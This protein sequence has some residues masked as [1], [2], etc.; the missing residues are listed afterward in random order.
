MWPLRSLEDGMAMTKRRGSRPLARVAIAGG[1]GLILLSASSLAIADGERG[2][3]RTSSQFDAVTGNSGAS[4]FVPNQRLSDVQRIRPRTQLG[5]SRDQLDRSRNGDLADDTSRDLN[6]DRD[7]RDDYREGLTSSG[8][9]HRGA[10][11][12][13]F[14]P[15][16]PDRID[17]RL[18]R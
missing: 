3:S 17:R 6:F 5:P 15:F 13:G 16:F 7:R 18:R 4:T 2:L 9:D 12:N 14:S 11:S 1:V 8:Y 10:R